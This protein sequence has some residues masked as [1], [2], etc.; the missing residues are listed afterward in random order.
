MTLSSRHP[1]LSDDRFKKL[2][3]AHEEAYARGTPI[4]QKGHQGVSECQIDGTDY[5]I[6][7]YRTSSP[8]AGLRLLIGQSRIDT[9]F[10][11]A[12]IL[13][14]HGVAA[15]KHLLIVKHPSFLKSRAFLVM[16][17]APG[18]ALFNFIQY[19]TDLKLSDTAMEN[20]AQLITGLHKLGIAHGDLHTRNLIIAQDDSVRLIDFDNARKSTNGIRKDLKRFQNAV[21][22]TS[23]YEPTIT[24]AMKRLGHPELID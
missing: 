9:S 8:L 6:K 19:G 11:Y 3:Q 20:I 14:T 7:C 5:M 17:K 16:E 18:I 2:M 13:N 4:N 23:S 15:A 10:R 1:E 12:E 22:V 24:A 21:A